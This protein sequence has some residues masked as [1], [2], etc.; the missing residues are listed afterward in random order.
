MPPKR[1]KAAA[2][3]A[4]RGSRTRAAATYDDQAPLDAS[5]SYDIPSQF[6]YHVA[7]FDDSD[8]DG[9]DF[10]MPGLWSSILSILFWS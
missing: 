6:D 5:S 4:A 8:D 7:I 2:T 10:L 1:K 3:T 9:D